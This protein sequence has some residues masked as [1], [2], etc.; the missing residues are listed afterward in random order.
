M[1]QLHPYIRRIRAEREILQVINEH[2]DYFSAELRGLSNVAIEKWFSTIPQDN[3]ERHG[4]VGLKDRLV[5]LG[6]VTKLASNGSHRG[7][8]IAPAPNEEIV[9]L[10]IAEL[11]KSVGGIV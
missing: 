8:M 7:A 4:V 3:K 6:N 11:R 2:A 1:S 9:Q 5:Y 10:C